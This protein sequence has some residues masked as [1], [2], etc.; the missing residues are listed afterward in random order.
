MSQLDNTLKLLGITDTN[1]QVFGTR[2]EFNG[3]GSGRKKDGKLFAFH[4]FDRYQFNQQNKISFL[5]VEIS[6]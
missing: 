4:G 5:K 1:I 3:R 2:E 6:K